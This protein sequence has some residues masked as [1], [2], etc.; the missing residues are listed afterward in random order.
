VG[1]VTSKP[2]TISRTLSPRDIEE[3]RAKN[4]CFLCD[5]AYFPL[6]KC[7]AQVYRLEVVEEIKDDGEEELREAEEELE[8]DGGAEQ[9]EPLQLS[10]NA[11]QGITTYHTMRVTGKVKNNPLHI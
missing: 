2:R 5:G 7:K 8:G 3:K 10:L 4:L 6:H 9:E 11:L 1:F